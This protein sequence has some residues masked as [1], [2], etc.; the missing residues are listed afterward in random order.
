MHRVEARY[1]QH[2]ISDEKASLVREVWER[3]RPAIARTLRQRR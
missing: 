3:I 2:P 1:S